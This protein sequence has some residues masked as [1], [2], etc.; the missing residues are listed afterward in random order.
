MGEKIVCSLQRT[1]KRRWIDR[2]ARIKKSC[3]NN[4]TTFID[5]DLIECVCVGT[6]FS[7]SGIYFCWCSF[8]LPN[9]ICCSVYIHML[10]CRID[11]VSCQIEMNTTRAVHLFLHIWPLW[12]PSHCQHPKLNDKGP[13]S[14]SF[15]IHWLIR[16]KTEPNV[17]RVHW[18]WRTV[19]CCCCWD[20]NVV[21][22]SIEMSHWNI[23][24]QKLAQGFVILLSR[25]T[26][27]S[28][29]IRTHKRAGE[30]HTHKHRDNHTIDNII[31]QRQSLQYHYRRALSYQCA[32]FN[33]NTTTVKYF[34]RLF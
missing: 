24:R 4:E 19:C 30:L 10:E 1:R 15:P 34:E 20:L 7:V 32:P 23:V 13:L 3:T 2:Y 26:H 8:E 29:T 6:D 33:C 27:T 18:K 16:K 31:D 11:F 9:A 21:L 25:T 28:L 5:G 17:S 22:I 14:T 12:R